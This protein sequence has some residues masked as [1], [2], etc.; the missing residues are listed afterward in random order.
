MSIFSKTKINRPKH[1][2]FGLGHDVCLSSDFF[3][4]TPTLF[5]KVMP[6][7]KWRMNTELYI[8]LAPMLAPIMARCDVKV[9]NFFVPIRLLWDEYETYYTGGQSGREEP[10]P[11]N[12]II[13]KGDIEANRELFG[14]G[15]LWDYLG[16]PVVT[17]DTVIANNFSKPICPLPFLAYYKVWQYYFSDQNLEQYDFSDTWTFPGGIQEIDDT[18]PDLSTDGTKR[19]FLELLKLRNACW[20]KDYFTSALPWPQRGQDVRLPIYGNANVVR[21]SESFGSDGFVDR[22]GNRIITSSTAFISG[23]SP[24]PGRSGI[25]QRGLPPLD[26]TLQYE[27]DPGSKPNIVGVD[28]TYNTKVAIQSTSVSYDPG[29]NLKVDLESASQATINEL[30]RGFA[31]QR[32]FEQSARVGWRF[33]EYLQGIWGVNNPDSRLQRPEFLGGGSTPVIIGE[34]LQTSETS[35]KSPLGDMAGR[36]VASGNKNGFTKFF[37]EPGF[38]ISLMVVRPRSSYSQGFPRQLEMLDRYDEPNPY[39]AHLGEQEVKQGELY[40]DFNAKSFGLDEAGNEKTDNDRTFGYQSRYSEYKYIPN[41]YHG[42]FRTSLDFWHLG[43]RFKGAP[44]LN[45]SFVT[46]SSE[47]TNHIFAVETMNGVPID[48]LW[49]QIHHNIKAN[50]PLPYHGTASL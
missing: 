29:N 16:F 33:W 34:V 21:N 17:E 49:C 12:V 41:S 32:F 25:V 8:R 6:G 50:R 48:H 46:G 47:E 30:R 18:E 13:R 31:L 7:D 4:I 44:S 28:T 38:V 24:G 15:S 9:Y 20:Q 27:D 5:Q 10:V 2:N 36:G 23:S 45:S 43:R 39:F 3:R 42:D 1:S 35:T 37:S 14:P 40:F 26:S 19:A 22:N 11:P